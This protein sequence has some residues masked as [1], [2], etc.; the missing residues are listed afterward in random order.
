MASWVSKIKHT[1]N[2]LGLSGKAESGALG[3]EDDVLALEEDITE[4]GE[5]D[6]RVA[7]DTTVAGRAA[8]SDGGE[9]DVF[10]GND[11]V[12]AIDDGGEGRKTG[13]AGEDITTVL[14]AVLSAGNLL[15]VVVDDAVIEQEEGG[16]GVYNGSAW[17]FRTKLRKTYQQCR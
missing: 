3:V 14:V 8:V 6:A 5:S 4:D 1:C 12:V 15:V 11:R 16:A 13:G 17:C 2:H 9:V 7:L 10:T